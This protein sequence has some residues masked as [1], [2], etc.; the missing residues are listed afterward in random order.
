MQISQ[1]Q[2]L[3]NEDE[4]G[5][6]NRIHAEDLTTVCSAAAEYGVDG[7]IFN[8][9]DGHPAS[10][11]AYFNACADALGMPR[12]PQVTLE[13]ARRVMSPLMFSYVNQSRIVDN[14]RMLEH[15]RVKLRYETMTAGLEATVAHGPAGER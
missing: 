9:S 13:E 7:D 11:T 1:G 2:P 8:V 3:L 10:M 5:P 4:S 14:R 12:Q 6:S 15:L